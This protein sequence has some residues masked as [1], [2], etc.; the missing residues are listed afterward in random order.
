M[1]KTTQEYVDG[2]AARFQADNK[3][4]KVKRARRVIPKTPAARVA[5]YLSLAAGERANGNRTCA[6]RWERLASGLEGGK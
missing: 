1:T 6:E 3:G 2:A 4:D 5:L